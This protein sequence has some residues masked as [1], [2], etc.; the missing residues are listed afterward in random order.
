M[1]D[2]NESTGKKRC[3]EC[4]RLLPLDR[5]YKEPMNRDKKM[6]KCKDC[7]NKYEAEYRHNH[8]LNLII[9]INE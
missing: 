6:G 2:A 1:N 4:G 7:R 3:K 9:Y 8:S 5:F